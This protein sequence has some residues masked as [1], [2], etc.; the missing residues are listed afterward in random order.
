MQITHTDL[1]VLKLFAKDEYDIDVPEI[2]V[3]S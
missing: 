1:G 2:N 3:P